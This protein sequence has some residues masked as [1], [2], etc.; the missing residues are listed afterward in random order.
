MESANEKAQRVGYRYLNLAIGLGKLQLLFLGSGLL[1]P[2][3]KNV[4]LLIIVSLL[5]V[6]PVLWFIMLL[7]AR[8]CKDEKQMV[9][10]LPSCMWFV[11]GAL[12]KQGSTLNPRT[13]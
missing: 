2:F 7:R 12:L 13:G 6:G 10:S 4:W 3:N 5:G 1:A 8:M 9:F 11:Y